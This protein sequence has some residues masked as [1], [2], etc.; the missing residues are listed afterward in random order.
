MCISLPLQEIL[1]LRSP[2]LG[3][4]NRFI[5][6]RYIFID[7]CGQGARSALYISSSGFRPFSN[8]HGFAFDPVAHL[9][10]GG[11]SREPADCCSQ[12]ATKK[13]ACHNLTNT[14]LI[15][16]LATYSFHYFSPSSEPI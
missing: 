10:A 13:H 12:N 8:P 7:L 6:V 5:D 16:V 14:S 4:S 3:A 11:G 2:L 9:R 15:A 1:G